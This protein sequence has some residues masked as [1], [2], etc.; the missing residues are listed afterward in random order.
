[1][2]LLIVSHTPHYRRDGELVG[3]GATVR[4]IDQLGEIF[5]RVVHLA[6]LCVEGAPES[7]I[8]YTSCRVRMRPVTA[9]GG[10]GLWNKLSILIRT[11]SYLKAMIQELRKADVVHVRCPANI[12]LIALLLLTLLPYPRKRWF[13]YAGNWKPEASEALSYTFQRWWLRKGWHRG[14]VTV[15]GEWPD[16]PSFV[17]SFLNPCLNYEELLEGRQLIGTRQ[18]SSPVRLIFAGRLDTGK[19]VGR[20]LHIMARLK[21]L[22][23]AATL[24]LIGD[25]E[26]RLEFEQL[27]RSLGIASQVSFHGWLPR[28]TLGQLYSRAHLILLPSTCS[29]G[30]PK[31]LSEAMAYGVVSIASN[32]SSI[33]QYFKKFGSGR[34]YASSD[35]DA[36]ANSI[37][38][39]LTHPGI[40]KEESENAVEA[41]NQ[42]SYANYLRAVRDV[43]DLPL[44]NSRSLR[45]TGLG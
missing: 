25:G 23:V 8:P 7:A 21:E 22:G 41:A 37:Q 33:P 29:E 19:G 31:V 5:D 17:H 13:K 34:T 42:F 40:W 24:D 45:A 27:A 6:P 11:P 10:N 32:V 12:S 3:W 1:M 28:S 4:E 35:V 26:E 36:F 15:N 30:W 9:A 39:Y 43:L 44:T 16:Q 18:I 20:I 14:V 38:W 2:N